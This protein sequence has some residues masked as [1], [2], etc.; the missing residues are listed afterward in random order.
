MINPRLVSFLG[1]LFVSIILSLHH[2]SRETSFTLITVCAMI[3]S[4]LLY[5]ESVRSYHVESKGGFMNEFPLGKNVFREKMDI[6]RRRPRQPV[7]DTTKPAVV[8]ETLIID[9][10]PKDDVMDGEH[11]TLAVYDDAESEWP[12]Q[13]MRTEFELIDTEAYLH[14]RA[15]NTDHNATTPP[16]FSAFAQDMMKPTSLPWDQ[17]HDDIDGGFTTGM[18]YTQQN[19]VARLLP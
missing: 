9:Y 17:S 6:G 15:Q 8:D 12:T 11:P 2:P 19:S 1:V 4:I 7:I 5:S 14:E 3:I 16:D 13:Q 18:P 10:Q